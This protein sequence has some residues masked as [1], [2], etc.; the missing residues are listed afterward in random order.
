VLVVDDEEPIR[1]VAEA[2]LK[3][4]GIPVFQAGSGREA[5][6]SLRQN[7]SAIKVVLLD[8][9]MP[10]LNG[11]E[12]LPFI[13]KLNPDVQVII[14]SGFSEVEVYRH[15]AGMKFRGFVPKPYTSE[16][17]LAQIVPALEYE[18]LNASDG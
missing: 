13:V 3:R 11:Y 2:I 1:S 8:M 14:S 12:A 17:L 7:L 18:S 9:T 4:R 10:D 16:K 15:F 6:E 5:I